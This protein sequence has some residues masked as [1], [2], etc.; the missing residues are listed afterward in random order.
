[1]PAAVG[2]S[3]GNADENRRRYGLCAQ[4]ETIGL[5]LLYYFGP[6]SGK[7]WNSFGICTFTLDDPARGM[8]RNS[9]HNAPVS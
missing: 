7:L 4:K 8:A 5:I 3:A 9:S 1:L 2:R 6:F